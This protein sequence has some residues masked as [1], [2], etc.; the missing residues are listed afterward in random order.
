[1]SDYTKRIIRYLRKFHTKDS[2]AAPVVWMEYFRAALVKFI[3][4]GVVEKRRWMVMMMLLRLWK[5]KAG[6]RRGRRT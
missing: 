3:N 4:T 5:W 2:A 6:E 1:M